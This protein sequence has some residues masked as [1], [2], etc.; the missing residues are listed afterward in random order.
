[1]PQPDALFYGVALRDGTPLASGTL[2]AILPRGDTVTV[3]IAPITGTPYNYELAVPLAYYDPSQRP[4]R[5]GFGRGWVRTSASPSTA[6]PR[7]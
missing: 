7:C 5:R 6:C 2:T 4:L 3:E 1:M